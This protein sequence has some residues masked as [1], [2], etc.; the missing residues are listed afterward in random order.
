MKK[1]DI[2]KKKEGWF[3]FKRMVKT[4][5]NVLLFLSILILSYLTI[6]R[7]VI[8]NTNAKIDLSN[9]GDITK[10]SN[11]EIHEALDDI[12]KENNLPPAIIDEVLENNE[13]KEIINDYVNEVINSAT[14]GGELPN[15]PKEKIESTITKGINKYNQKYN[16]NISVDK[17]K[18]VVESFATKIED[19][20]NIF[21][22]GIS[23]LGY[24]Q[25][26]LNNTLYYTVLGVVLVLILLMAIFYKKE[27]LFSLG[28][29]TIFNGIVLF[30]TY[31]IVKIESITNLLS[32][33]PF[34]LK[35]MQNGFFTGGIIFIMTG[36]ILLIMYKFL[37]IWEE[38][39]QNQ[40]RK[41]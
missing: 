3:M 29:I 35:K 22:Q 34:E 15:I 16:T 37:C 36:I 39:K 27:F 21:Y 17:V 19:T 26:L 9:I 40:K 4:V 7:G 38:K 23:F 41:N 31:L 14:V 18:A 8:P 1:Y 2:M 12:L 30:L 20:L 24:F 6:L 28:G 10:Y 32:F 5:L 33:L 13:S 25:I 11:K